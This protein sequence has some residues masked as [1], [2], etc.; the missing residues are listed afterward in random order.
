MFY[1]LGRLRPVH[2][3]RVQANLSE[4]AQIAIAVKVQVAVD[5]NEEDFVLFR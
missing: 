5:V 1:R 2:N 3:Q 4:H